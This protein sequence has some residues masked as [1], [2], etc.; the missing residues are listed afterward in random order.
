M[1]AIL[2]IFLSYSIKANEPLHWA[3]INAVSDRHEF[4]KNNEVISKP[5][6]AWQILFSLQYIDSGLKKLKDCVYYLVPGESPGVLKIK[7]MSASTSCDESILS[8]G[9]REV[10]N[11][12]SLQF[13]VTEKGIDLDF[14]LADFQNHKWQAKL[15][16]SSG[17]RV[18]KMQ[19]SSAEYKSAKILL[20]AP[21]QNTK[22]PKVD[23]YK[24]KTLCHNINEDCME[25]SPSFCSQCPEGWYEIPNGCSEG[26]KYCGVLE[27]GGKDQPACR[28]GMKWQRKELDFDCRTNSSFAYCSKGLTIAC[29]GKK[30]FCR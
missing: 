2:I 10:K 22:V 30:A 24:P 15:P 27:C 3:Y 16:A 9:D 17:V 1:I 4:Y 7:T 8:S 13:A 11:I 26:P 14:T 6:D 23:N 18:P 19:T 25:V 20:L 28:R 5:K 21:E 12:K 29:E